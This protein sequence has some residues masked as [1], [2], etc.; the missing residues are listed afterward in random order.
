MES[1]SD[2]VS[3]AVNPGAQTTIR[4][5]EDAPRYDATEDYCSSYMVRLLVKCERKI[6][7]LQVKAASLLQTL[8]QL[9]WAVPQLDNLPKEIT[10]F[11]QVILCERDH[12]LV[13]GRIYARHSLTW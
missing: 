13:V 3:P 5:S 8:G 10:R 6:E 2:W 1:Y 7:T 4:N 12:L 9:S 11:L